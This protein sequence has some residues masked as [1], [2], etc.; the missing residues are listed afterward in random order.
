MSRDTEGKM[1]DTARAGLEKGQDGEAAGPC[2]HGGRRDLEDG[3]A[4][5]VAFAPGGFLLISTC[6]GLASLLALWVLSS[7]FPHWI[8]NF[9]RAERVPYALSSFCTAVYMGL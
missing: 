1:G 2:T 4:G 7:S 6:L 3:K 8:I 5:L 9:S